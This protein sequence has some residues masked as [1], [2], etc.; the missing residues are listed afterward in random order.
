MIADVRGYTTYTRSHGDEAAGDLA[1][2]FA[3]VVRAA[4][5]AADGRLVETRGDEALAAFS[6]ARHAV[7]AAVDLQRRLRLPAEG[8]VR[9]HDE[10]LRWQR[11][12]ASDLL[13]GLHR[14][15]RGH[16]TIL[17]NQALSVG[18]PPTSSCE[19]VG[20]RSMNGALPGGI[21]LLLDL[22]S[23]P[24]GPCTG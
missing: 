8:A 23:C 1:A 9:F 2:R 12:F 19:R 21:P 15:L 10:P 5:E 18:P 17:S 24:Y 7:G 16:V 20:G 14:R 4:T 22:P 13:A 3:S 6:S 11:R